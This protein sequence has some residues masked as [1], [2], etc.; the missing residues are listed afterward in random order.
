[1]LN[2][3]FEHRGIWSPSR[4]FFKKKY[5]LVFNLKAAVEVGVTSTVLTDDPYSW[6]QSQ[7]I[8]WTAGI[9]GFIYWGRNSVALC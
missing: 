7:F 4:C 8:W 2:G 6:F 1:M 9:R 5:V 3:W